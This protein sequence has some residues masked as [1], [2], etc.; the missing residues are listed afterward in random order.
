[1]N[2]ENKFESQDVHDE[3]IYFQEFANLIVA[4]EMFIA[5]SSTSC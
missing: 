5:E 1:M 2:S 4:L 3:L